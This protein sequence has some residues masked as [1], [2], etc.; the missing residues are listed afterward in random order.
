[1]IGAG[2]ALLPAL[3]TELEDDALHGA[4]QD[5]IGDEPRAGRKQLWMEAQQ[6]LYPAVC[7]IHLPKAFDQWRLEAC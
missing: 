1:M 3:Y 6:E 5:G 7:F 4:Q 2:Q